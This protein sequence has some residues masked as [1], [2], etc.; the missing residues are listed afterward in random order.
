MGLSKRKKAILSTKERILLSKDFIMGL[1]VIPVRNNYLKRFMDT[2]SREPTIDE[3][4]NYLYEKN[5]TDILLCKH[6]LYEMNTHKDEGA[7][8]VLRSV[9]G[10]PPENGIITCKICGNYLCPENFKN[11][12]LSH[13]VDP[14]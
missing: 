5:S 10:N 8:N 9:F 7:F 3:D 12:I 13:L 14:Y 6:Y 2:F 11:I 4:S 1:H